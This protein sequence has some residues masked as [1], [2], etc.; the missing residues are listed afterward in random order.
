M[1]NNNG[2]DKLYIV[3]ISV[4]GLIR[5]KNLEL[6]RD[7]DTGGQTL[8]V[9]ELARALAERDDVARVDLL[10]RLVEDPKV[11]SDYSRPQEELSP[12]ANLIRLRCGPRRY[13]RK[14]VLWP[15]LDEFIDHALQHIRSVGQ[16]PDFIHGHYADAGLV[17]ARVAGL[18]G[19][20]MIFTGHS[21]GREKQRQ[22]LT[23]G[24]KKE[25]LESQYNLSQRIEA[26]EIALGTAAMIV[27]STHQE[28]EE[29][30]AKYDNYHPSRME[31]IPPGVD[32][33]RYRPPEQ[34]E[35]PAEIATEL[36]RFIQKPEKPMILALSRADERKNITT[37]VKAYGESSELQK[38]ANLVLIAGNRDD[39]TQMEKGP[40]EVLKEL[41]LQFDKYDLYG[42]V[43]YPK[44][45]NSDDV[46]ALYR[47]AAQTCGV[48]VNPA[49][50][51]P[52]GLTLIEAAASGLP[53]VATNDGGPSE[54][55]ANCQNGILIDPHDSEGIADALLT[56]LSDRKQWR[57]WSKQGYEGAHRHYSWEGHAKTYL[58]KISGFRA[59]HYRAPFVPTGKTRLVS[60]DRIG[61]TAIDNA[62]FGDKAA[63]KRLLSYLKENGK[64]IGFGLATGRT[65]D[66]TLNFLKRYNLPTPDILVTSV[67]TE[68]HYAHQDERIVE[69]NLWRRNLDYRWEPRVLRKAMDKCPGVELAPES[70]QR[71]H[72][73]SYKLDPEKAP[74][75]REI[76]RHLRRH[77]LHAKAILS[78]KTHLDLLPIRASK[79]LAIRYLSMKWGIPLD[80]ILVVG[81]SGND[82]EMLQGSTLGVV[83]ANHS[84]ELDKLHDKPR[85]YFTEKS[86]ADGIIEGIEYYNFLDKTRIPND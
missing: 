12:K 22:L 30:Y 83:V 4:H 40:R 85:I 19:S 3:L 35:K 34:D 1:K 25:K 16:V 31:V 29:Q 63:L 26:E 65:L 56:A 57:L 74:S 61:F 39:I 78:E 33:G 17:A 82:E 21:L 77:D 68:I 23:K 64:D 72:K 32:I 48:F 20:P 13:L 51:E 37:L 27:A 59:D 53:I 2:E 75:V 71:E 6:G 84:P 38:K 60:L 73:I 54:I 43:A 49:W 28:V 79:G 15:H 80:R 24:I 66:S 10:T 14:E 70:E 67:G 18:L 58:E 8:Y 36:Q 50:T 45:H 11:D 69:D 42:K 52:F 41:L 9:V 46:P 76:K 86:Y 81:D 62:L 47:L 7:A 5:A 44:H 55:I